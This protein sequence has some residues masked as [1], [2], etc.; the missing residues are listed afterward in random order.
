MLW[1]EVAGVKEEPSAEEAVQAYLCFDSYA[2]NV[3]A[4]HDDLEESFM[5]AMKSAYPTVDVDVIKEAIFSEFMGE[6]G[7]SKRAATVESPIISTKLACIS[8]TDGSVGALERRT[9]FRPI[10]A[11]AES[12]GAAPRLSR[13]STSRVI[14]SAAQEALDRMER[15]LMEDP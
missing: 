7:L 10:E 12:S 8:D 13:R 9:S 1:A 6:A 5:K 14:P 4:V 2:V 15:A 3:D 11:T